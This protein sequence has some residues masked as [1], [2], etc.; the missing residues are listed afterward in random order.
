MGLIDGGTNTDVIPNSY[1]FAHL[2]D[3]D[4]AENFA[5]QS[6]STTFLPAM[7]LTE[8]CYDQM[9]YNCDG[10]TTSIPELPAKVLKNKCYYRMFYSCEHMAYANISANEYS[11]AEKACEEMFVRD[12]DLSYIGIATLGD[13]GEDNFKN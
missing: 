9:F 6:V 10:L 3:A 5:V 1:C 4:N 8:G 13:F 7:T 12:G 2:F 11:S